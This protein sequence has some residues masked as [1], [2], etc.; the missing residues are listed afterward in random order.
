VCVRVWQ[1]TITYNNLCFVSPC[2]RVCE[3]GI[4]ITK[5]Q[6]CNSNMAS[7]PKME[8]DTISAL[9]ENMGD[10]RSRKNKLNMIRKF[11]DLY[12]LLYLL[13]INSN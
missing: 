10:F 6:S 1:R 7:S 9:G 5:E 12:I 3:L 8:V 2:V 11:R 13:L 4:Q